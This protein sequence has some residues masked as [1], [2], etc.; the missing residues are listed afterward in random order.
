MH[1]SAARSFHPSSFAAILGRAVLRGLKWP[2]KMMQA[3]HDMS[4]LANM[5]AH[6]LR[7]I[8]LT[9][10]D[11]ANVT[12]LALDDDPTLFLANVARDRRRGARLD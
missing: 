4:L 1:N 9:R 3:R 5:D 7:D 6:E 8:G 2:A 10:A 11:I 12:A